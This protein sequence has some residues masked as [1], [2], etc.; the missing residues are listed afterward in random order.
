MQ[1]SSMDKTWVRFQESFK[2]IIASILY[3][4]IRFGKLKACGIIYQPKIFAAK[5]IENF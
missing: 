2:N 4:F 3:N 1:L 5:K